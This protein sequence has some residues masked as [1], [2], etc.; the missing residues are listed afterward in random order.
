MS[1]IRTCTCCG[2]TYSYCPSCGNGPSWKMLYDTETCKDIMNI[3]SGYNMNLIS[4]NQATE[5]LQKINI[6]NIATYNDNVAKTLIELSETPVEKP[7]K[8]RRKR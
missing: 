5:S 2:K 7:K 4:K 1:K 3:V 6:G 8:R